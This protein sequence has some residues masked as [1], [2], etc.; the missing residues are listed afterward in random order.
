VVAA[1]AVTIAVFTFARTTY[2]RQV[3]PAAPDHG[4]PF[5]RA[6]YNTIEARRAFAEQGVALILRSKL[7]SMTELGDRG[8]V[9]EVTVFG[10]A[11]KVAAAGFYDY[12]TDTQGHYVRFPTTCANGARLVERWRSNVRA[13]VLCSGGTATLRRVERA[14]AHLPAR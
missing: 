4:L 6:K 2:H 13:I 9:V 1:A 3:E 7:P 11:A 8:S 10:S 5:A 14:L 12:T